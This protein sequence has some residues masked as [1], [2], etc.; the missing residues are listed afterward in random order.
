[1][2]IVY[3][4]DNNY[5]DILGVSIV[6][7]F[8]NNR[9]SKEI[10][11]YILDDRI[12]E[13]NH[14]KL[15]SIGEKYGRTIIFIPVPDLNKL[16][17]V[18][19]H[20]NDRWSMSAFSR[21]FL[22]KIMPISVEQVI[23][24][25]C[26]I[27]VNDSLEELFY[28]DLGNYYCAGVSDCIS[29]QHKANVGLRRGDYY[30]NSGVMLISLKN[31]RN[32]Q[33]CERFVAF[34]DEFGGDIPYVDQGVINGT[35]SEYIMPLELKFNCYTAIYDFNYKDL[36]RYRKPTGF[37]SEN[38][39]RVA[40]EKP[41]IVHFT[42]SFLSLRPWVEGC[43]HPYISEWLKYKEISPWAD[44]PLRKDNRSFKKK[45]AVLIYKLIPN[46]I[47]VQLSGLLHARIVPMLSK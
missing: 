6:S 41:S 10:N 16:A 2:N 14:I 30:I 40:K 47:A 12:Q 17:G 13:D 38:E 20:A 34:I 45:L 7:L 33:L 42:T 28:T 36:M 21:L 15:L 32:N 27:L 23:Y 44:N 46:C 39:V 35:I 29:D 5:A 26:D 25:D 43:Q 4:S 3:A 1:M 18:S 31:W 22:E 37:Y 9:N 11:V 19:I 24:L 8:E